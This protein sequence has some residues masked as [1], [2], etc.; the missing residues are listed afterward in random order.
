MVRHDV[1]EV[2]CCLEGYGGVVVVVDYTRRRGLGERE[3]LL[4]VYLST[5]PIAQRL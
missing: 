2:V 5:P 4:L 1:S 3:G